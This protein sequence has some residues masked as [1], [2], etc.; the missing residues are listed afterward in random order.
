MATASFEDE[1]KHRLGPTLPERGL[2]QLAKT[3]TRLRHSVSGSNSG[4]RE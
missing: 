1:L 3:L 2:A 4:P